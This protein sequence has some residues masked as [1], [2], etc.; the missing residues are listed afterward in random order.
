L[1]TRGACAINLFAGA[2]RVALLKQDKARDLSPLDKERK[3]TH[4]AVRDPSV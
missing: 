3:P 1:S 4:R 2:L